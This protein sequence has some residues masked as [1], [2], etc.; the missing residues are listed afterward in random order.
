MHRF[1][2]GGVAETDAE[3]EYLRLAKTAG[4]DAASSGRR[5]RQIFFRIGRESWVATVGQSPAGT[6]PVHRRQKGQLAT[7]TE[8]LADESIVL[9]IFAGDPFLIV[10][11]AAPAGA[12]ESRWTGP[13]PAKPSKIV[14]FDA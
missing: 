8:K 7:T 5:V 3:A 11:T 10:T 13:V 12:A 2:V 4:A 6:R 1:F 9:A 14:Y